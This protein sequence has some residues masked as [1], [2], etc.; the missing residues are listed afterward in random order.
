MIQNSDQHSSD[1]SELRDKPRPGHADYTAFVKWQGQ[2]DMRG[3]GHFSGR[4]T[5]PLCIAGG[6]AKQILARRGIFVGAHLASVGTETD[7]AF[8]LLPTAELFEAVAAKPFPVLNDAAGE[9]MAVRHSGIPGG[10]GF[11][12]RRH[13]VQPPSDFP[14]DWAGPCL[15][16][17][18][19]AWRRPSSAF[20]PSR[21][22]SSAPALPPP[23][24]RLC[25]QRPLYHLRRPRGH[26]HQPRRRHPGRHHQRHA[27]DAASGCQTHPIHL[28]APAYRLPL[29]HGGC[30]ADHPGP[31]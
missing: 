9:R 15:T 20:P 30:G 22:W 17:W 26:N 18:R 16:A 5:A 23:V 7:D 27:P 31:A 11:C 8:P 24:L 29:C 10:R 14:P 28:P 2:A 4:L 21:A 12:G 25:Q 6:I 13:R 19:T 1:Y 3:G